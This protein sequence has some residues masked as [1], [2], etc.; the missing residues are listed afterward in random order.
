MLGNGT[1]EKLPFRQSHVQALSSVRA[2]RLDSQTARAQFFTRTNTDAASTTVRVVDPSG[3]TV[4]SF[5]TLQAAIDD[6]AKGHGDVATITIASGQTVTF[7]TDTTLNFAA[8]QRSFSRVRVVGGKSVEHSDVVLSVAPRVIGT[9]GEYDWTTPTLTTGGLTIGAHANQLVYNATTG[10]Y[11][12]IYTNTA[13]ELEAPGVPST[14]KSNYIVSY[15]EGVQAAFTAGD[16]LTI[17]TPAATLELTNPVVLKLGGETVEFVE[18]ALNFA[19]EGRFVSSPKQP[20]HYRVSLTGCHIDRAD[21]GAIERDS[22]LNVPATLEGCVVSESSGTDNGLLG[23]TDQNFAETRYVIN[24]VVGGGYLGYYYEEKSVLNIRVYGCMFSDCPVNLLADNGRG[25]MSVISCE[26][27]GDSSIDVRSSDAYIYGVN[28]VTVVGDTPRINVDGAHCFVGDLL[29]ED[30]EGRAIDLDHQSTMTVMGPMT[31][32]GFA[33]NTSSALDISSGSYLYATDTITIDVEWDTGVRVRHG[34]L[35]LNSE[36]SVSDTSAYVWNI[37]SGSVVTSSAGLAGTGNTGVGIRLADQS[38][39][40]IDNATVTVAGN[41]VEL[42]AAGA[43]T[44]AAVVAGL[45][46]DVNDFGTASPQNCMIRIL[47]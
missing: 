1:A 17:Y 21:L 26:V 2:R 3:A 40:L 28:F 23:T 4:D 29:W 16:E 36:M 24:S 8:L 32:H 27:R 42:G 35:V 10:R 7:E 43:K 30:A 11:H 9:M 37:E 19:D 31:I 39:A 12:G 45:A 46:A 47:I 41:Q 25:N 34:R 5:A 33:G 38:S 14:T 15:G 13:T 44:F 20:A 22:P 6:L 18:L